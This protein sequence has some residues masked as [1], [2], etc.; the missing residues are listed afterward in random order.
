MVSTTKDSACTIEI[1]ITRHLFTRRSELAREQTVYRRPL[2]S[3]ASSLLRAMATKT[4]NSFN[5]PLTPGKDWRPL[6][7][8]ESIVQADIF[9]AGGDH[10][11]FQPI[12][13]AELAILLRRRHR[14]YAASRRG[15]FPPSPLDFC[16]S[17]RTP[18]GRG[19][20][21]RLRRTAG[22]RRLESVRRRCPTGSRRAMIFE[23]ALHQQRQQPQ[24]RLVQ[25][26]QAGLGQQRPADHQHLLFAVGQIAR[27]PLA[28]FVQ[29]REIVIDQGRNS[30]G[31]A[32]VR[33]A[34]K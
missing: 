21:I 14:R 5:G 26:H 3:R 13:D 2:L 12:H 4:P 29:P 33:S 31:P 9:A 32:G 15:W 20:A 7:S 16:S 28:P 24:R 30:D 1:G 17:R 27:Q 8:G 10:D 23:Q 22:A 18:S 6:G 11:V 19:S 34:H 25:Q